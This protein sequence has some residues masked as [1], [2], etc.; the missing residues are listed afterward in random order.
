MIDLKKYFVS[1]Y[2]QANH[3]L[4]YKEISQI[5]FSSD[6]CFT[7]RKQDL[8]RL[9][10]ADLDPNLRLEINRGLLF[11][12]SIIQSFMQSQEGIVFAVLDGHS[13]ISV[14]SD[15]DLAKKVLIRFNCDNI[16]KLPIYDNDD[17]SRD[18]VMYFDDE[19]N[20]KTVTNANHE[21]DLF[22]EPKLF[23]TG[24][25]VKD[26]MSGDIYVLSVDFDDLDEPYWV[27]G[28]YIDESNG[29]DFKISHDHWQLLYS[30]EPI[31]ANDTQINPI[32]SEISKYFI[33]P[34]N[35]DQSRFVE[36]FKSQFLKKNQDIDKIMCVQD[37]L[38]LD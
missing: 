29:R 6:L 3:K 31:D 28:Y 13:F 10:T 18:L 34:E 37:V 27:T 25:I 7:E 30:L 2:V 9:L 22:I 8:E 17:N 14:L 5:I 36:T 20:I 32:L 21:I 23:K 38:C 16:R 26:L 1:D 19:F 11:E 33:D 35:Y 24:D 15:F 12:S 4:S